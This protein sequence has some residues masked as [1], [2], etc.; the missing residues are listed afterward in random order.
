M[1]DLTT[2]MRAAREYADAQFPGHGIVELV[3]HQPHGRATRIAL[4]VVLPGESSGVC[5][6][7][8]PD[9]GDNIEANILQA[10]SE[11]DGEE[12]LTGQRL[13]PLAGYPFSGHFRQTLAEMVRAERLQN[14]RNGY[15]IPS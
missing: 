7:V 12:P 11:Y 6:T 4:P 14:G 3:I 10:V 13:A 8:G 2:L 9:D 15:S 1:T 5:A